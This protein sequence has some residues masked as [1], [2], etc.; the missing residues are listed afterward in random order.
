MRLL[1]S[2]AAA[3]AAG[4]LALTHPTA[5]TPPDRYV[6]PGDRAFPTGLA[7]DP[8]TGHFYVGSAEDGTLRRGHV[9]SPTTTVWS[10]DGRDG[11]TFTAGM[12]LDGEGRL[13]VN[14]GPTSTLR[15]YDTRKR[16]MLAELDGV[17]GGFVNDVAPAPDG[18]AYV[19]DSFEPVIYRVAREDGRW[20]M[21]PWLDVKAAGIGWID[22]EH[23]LNGIL[24]VGRHLLAV[25]SNTGQLW[26]IDPA[27][28]E[29]VEVDL[30]GY[31]L[32][33][34][35]G[36][37]WGDGRLFVSQGNLF[38]TPGTEAQVAVVTMNSD[39]TRGRYAAGLVPPR[40]LRHPSAVALT[41]GREERLLVVNSQFGR[42]SAGLP[43]ETLPFTIASLRVPDGGP[44]E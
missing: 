38:D 15:V 42:W 30:G 41:G 37:A 11:R 14:G 13:Y 19:T 29:V 40:G 44:R 5:P 9:D 17:A 35:D 28:R 26:R 16:V 8:R 7:H 32:R 23:N 31:L 36:L 2:V 33:N 43:P 27:T 4:S 34:G 25:Q 1:V 22:G 24:S 20:E 21:E 39:L 6:V 3:V 12:A 10:P 18:A